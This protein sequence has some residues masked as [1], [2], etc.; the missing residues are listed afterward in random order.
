MASDQLHSLLDQIADQQPYS[1]LTPDEFNLLFNDSKLVK[2]EPGQI[3]LRPDELPS[4]LFLVV[5]G[6]I[7]LLAK[8]PDNSDAITLCKR[9]SGQLVGWVSLLRCS[10]CEWVI[11]SE[12]SIVLTISA[13]TFLELFTSNKKF[14]HSFSSLPHPQETYIVA[15]E[16]VKA[17]PLLPEE[18]ADRL[19]QYTS[20]SH[21]HSLEAGVI[22]EP[23][24]DYGELNWLISTQGLSSHQT[25][26]TISVGDSII[27]NNSIKLP[28]R[29]VGI[30]NSPD[31]K[32]EIT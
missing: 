16:Y 23:P 5:Q 29:C 30:P 18:W 8:R 24:K 7:R 4:R 20:S 14:A 6:S 13:Y 25:G 12:D 3:I 1:I 31:F 21:V 2:Y 26:N 32:K 9:G 15:S 27:S 17:Q 22:F 10:P 11:S 28:V 19:F